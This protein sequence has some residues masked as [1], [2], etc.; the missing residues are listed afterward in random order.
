ML[1]D[2]ETTRIVRSWLEDGRTTLPD[3]V[4]DAVLDQ[5]P[6]TP[7]RRLPWPAR[8][9]AD[10]NAFA[11]FAAAAAAVVLVAVVGAGLLPGFGAGAPTSTP[12]PSPTPVAT[13]TLMPTAP[14]PPV[15]DVPPGR[16]AWSWPDGRVSFDVP[17]GWRNHSSDQGGIERNRDTP[18]E[19]GLANWLPG[20]WTVVSRVYDDACGSGETLVDIGGTT[21]DL[22]TALEA[23]IGTSTTVTETEIGGRPAFRIEVAV[24]P[25]I[26]PTT[27]R[28]GPDGPIQIWN[29]AQSGYLALFP[30]SDG[31]YGEAVVWS[32]DVDGERLIFT[33]VTNADT[34]P[35]DFAAIEAMIDSMTFE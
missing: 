9:I 11:K 17:S 5:L 8:R 29:Q 31:T 23:Q 35:A 28:V 7:Q 32:V 26:D 18:T 13:P 19:I 22:V 20:T 33:A 6:A 1:T 34:D 14:P 15:G 3:D 2:R 24:D 21:A 27:C 30:A 25:A 4:L 10:M 16:Y 12:A